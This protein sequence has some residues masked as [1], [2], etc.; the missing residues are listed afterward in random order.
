VR[1]FRFGSWGGRRRRPA[2]A[3][4]A[5]GAFAVLAGT[6][7]S[8][9]AAGE[10]SPIPAAAG[11]GASAPPAPAAPALAPPAVGPARG[12]PLRVLSGDVLPGLAALRDSGAPDPST[13]VHVGV[14][15]ADPDPAGEAAA[16]QALYRPGDPHFHRFLTPGEVARRFGEPRAVVD[17]LT[18]WLSGGG[19]RVT[20]LAAS[21]DFVQAT[22]SVAQVERLFRTT[23]R[24]YTADGST[25]SANRT[26]PS[27]PA[28]LPVI[29]VM[30]L[31]SRQRFHTFRHR[32]RP[33]PVPEA[34]AAGGIKT[35]QLSPQELWDVY[36]QPPDNL[37]QGATMAIIGAGQ[38]ETVI[39]DLRTFESRHSFPRMLTRVHYVGAG[40]HDDGTGTAEWD[41]D[42]QA[43]SGMAPLARREDF[44]FASS[45]ADAD[46]ATGLS[47]W[48]S[49]PTGPLQASA[50]FGECETDPLN[51]VI[52]DPALDPV[53][54][55]QNPRAQYG[56][57]LG[58]N[59]QPVAEQI[60]AQ[61][62]LQG[63]TL[64]VSTGDTGSSCPV[65]VLPGVSAGNGVLNQ[66]V[67][68]T[69]YPASSRFAVG[70]G[71]TVLYTDGS[72]THPQRSVE[73]AWPFTG[74]GSTLLI[75]AP[76]WQAPTAGDGIPCLADSAGRTSATGQ[77]CRGIPDITAISGDAVGNGYTVIVDG[78]D[79]PGG[80]TSLS[81]PLWLGMWARIQ[82]AS[83]HPGG[84]GFANPALYAAGNDPARAARDFHDVTVG[85]NGAYVA[86]PG[87]DYVSGFGSPDVANLMLD[88]DGRTQ[89]LKVSPAT[90]A[91]PPQNAL[92]P[93]EG[94]AAVTRAVGDL[95]GALPAPSGGLARLEAIR[96]RWA[97][98]STR[99][100]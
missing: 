19:L 1:G 79:V 70:V 96:T 34:A 16:I 54:P 65:L 3:L 99:P 49:D 15:L 46:V 21:G 59:L 93:P 27:V 42:S 63:K 30:G 90:L 20:H 43:S 68:L 84:N 76:E 67:P 62:V 6:P 26:A 13:S 17:R 53:N 28:G 91:P 98:R 39:A 44:Y 88:L 45:L 32:P 78:R 40:P 81:A 72:A 36:H 23:L 100:R 89:P 52:S 8:P 94:V 24:T 85:A 75:P 77:R 7:G 57:E 87:W 50:S 73:Y 51:P 4:A 66:A 14:G 60:L 82:A 48:V 37:G 29:S 69:N 12:A 31:D 10:P 25:F 61:G 2:L 58:D 5:G 11:P 64:F 92:P 71:G 74:G 41:L 22:G 55:D 9:A 80:G 33:G 83:P 56:T 95:L 18:T 35:G 86:R 97:G 38:V 47:A